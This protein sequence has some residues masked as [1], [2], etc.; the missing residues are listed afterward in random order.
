MGAPHVFSTE[1]KPQHVDDD[2]NPN[3]PQEVDV[4]QRELGFQVRHPPLGVDVAGNSS[5]TGSNSR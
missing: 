5:P 1:V 2:Q 3:T 4:A